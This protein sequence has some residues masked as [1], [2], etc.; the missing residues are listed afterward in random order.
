MI[1]KKSFLADKFV[2]L[3]VSHFHESLSSESLEIVEVLADGFLV[4]LVAKGGLFELSS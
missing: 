2:D 1:N 3:G 4:H